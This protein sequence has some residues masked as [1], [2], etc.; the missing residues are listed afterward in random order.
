MTDKFDIFD[1]STSTSDALYQF[2]RAEINSYEFEKEI[3]Y[4]EIKKFIRKMRR[5]GVAKF[6][7]LARRWCTKMGYDWKN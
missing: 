4:P 1:E 2:A 7:M 3:I 5:N 6:R